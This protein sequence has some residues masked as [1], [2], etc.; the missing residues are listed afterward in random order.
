MH[1][2]ATYLV[3]GL[4]SIA[5]SSDPATTCTILISQSKSSSELQSSKP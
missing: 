1:L 4:S 3:T 5:V 2:V